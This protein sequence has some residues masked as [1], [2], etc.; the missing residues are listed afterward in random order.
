MGSAIIPDTERWNGIPVWDTQLV[1]AELVN[2]CQERKAR[3]G[4]R[5]PALGPDLAL[6]SQVCGGCTEAKGEKVVLHETPSD[7]GHSDGP[8]ELGLDLVSGLAREV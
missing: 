7:S 2:G 1:S 8:R 5:I 3:R 4:A 6:A